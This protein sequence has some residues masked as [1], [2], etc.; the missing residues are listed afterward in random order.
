MDISLDLLIKIAIATGSGIVIGL[1][2]E[3]SNVEDRKIMAGF[4]TFPLISL[5]GFLCAFFSNIYTPWLIV[6]GFGGVLL[7][8]LVSKIVSHADNTGTTTGAALLVTYFSGALIYLDYIILSVTI[9]VIV[10]FLLSLK[11]QFKTIAGNF[12][13]SDIYALLQFIVISGIILPV[14]PDKSYPPY[15]VI[16][17]REIWIMVVLISGLSL[18]GY[19]LN[20]FIGSEKSILVTGIV[21]SLASTTAVTWDYSNKSAKNPSYSAHYAVGIILGSSIMY[22]RVFIIA[23]LVNNEFAA[24]LLL[25][26][27]LLTF[28]GFVASFVIYKFSPM[29]KSTSEISLSNPL[30][31]I[32]AFK[33]AF[34]FSLTLFLISM[35]QKYLGSSGVY[36]ISAL[37]GST[38]VDPTTISLAKMAGKSLTLEIAAAAL[39]IGTIANSLVK[40]AM[41]MIFGS[42]ELRKIT[43][44][45]F[46]AVI[47]TGIVYL[48][49]KLNF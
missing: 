29:P 27:F 41:C 6:A 22:I 37:S 31:M 35:A 24:V 48:V 45:G 39:I 2:R 26:V 9:M 1:E 38:D 28:S 13:Q 49:I 14:L 12:N 4:R 47:L 21:G 32:D 11:L 36:F 25:P 3:F 8:V 7:L 16:N 46:G 10:T 20:K 43:S 34:L 5:F 15:E 33:F 23:W 19:I 42:D 40:Y 17:P 18:A 30:N 44:A